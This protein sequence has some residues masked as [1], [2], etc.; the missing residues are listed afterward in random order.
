MAAVTICSDFEAP[1]NQVSHCLHCFL[2]YLPWNDRS[3]A[4]ILV[5]WMLSFKPTFSLSSFTFIKRLFSSLLPAIRVVLSVYLRLLVFL[6]AIL[7][8]A[9]ASATTSKT[10]L[11]DSGES[12]PLSCLVP[13]LMGNACSFSPLRIMF[14]VALSCMAFTIHFLKSFNH[15]WVLNF[16]RG[17]FYIYLEYHM[18]FI[19]QFVNMVYHIGL[20]I[21]KNT[22]IPGRNPTW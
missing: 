8:P 3:D 14:A 11:N 2:I 10:I 9:C 19:F 1:K 6:A 15:K 20:C 17:L 13:D 12:G 21:L 22:C 5:F 7:I 4:M 16:V 18:V